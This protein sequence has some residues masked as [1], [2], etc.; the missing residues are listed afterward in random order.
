MATREE[1]Y[2][3]IDSEREYHKSLSR[4]GVQ[5]NVSKGIPRHYMCDYAIIQKIIR[6]AQDRFYT[7]AGDDMEA[8]MA[9]MRKIAGV[10]VKSMEQNGA[11]LRKQS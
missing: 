11:P 6:D 5:T 8:Q 1:V 7:T 3:A 4:N 10:V 2:V 9:F